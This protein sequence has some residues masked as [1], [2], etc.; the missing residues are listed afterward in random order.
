MLDNA[1]SF[2]HVK[3]ISG[4]NGAD[5]FSFHATNF[6]HEERRLCCAAI[7][8]TFSFTPHF[9]YLST[10]IIVGKTLL[11]ILNNILNPWPFLFFTIPWKGEKLSNIKKLKQMSFSNL[12]RIW[13][14]GKPLNFVITYNRLRY[15][16]L[17]VYL[18]IHMLQNIDFL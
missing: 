4:M 1:L 12:C 8:S 13:K 3:K 7:S 6:S 17:E 10:R 16:S 5:V 15:W 9:L 2:Q 11:N 18:E 14:V